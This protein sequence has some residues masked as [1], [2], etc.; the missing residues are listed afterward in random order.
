VRAL[1]QFLNA[2]RDGW[3]LD[4]RLAVAARMAAADAHRH[5]LTA[6]R[7]VVA[8]KDAW[9]ALAEARQ[10][11]LHEGRELRDRL[12]THG[13]RAYYHRPS[14]HPWPPTDSGGHVVTRPAA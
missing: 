7:M 3:L 11:P 6:E 1:R 8:L 13:I 2:Y 14:H 12:V 9:A 4:V 5:G 10:L